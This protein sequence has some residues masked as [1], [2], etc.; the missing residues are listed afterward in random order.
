VI[1]SAGGDSSG[2]HAAVIA[3][4]QTGEFTEA[5]G[6]DSAVIASTGS[7]AS[8]SVQS[9]VMAAYESEASGDRSACVAAYSS[10]ASGAV[11]ACFASDA[12]EAAG[13][14]S[15]TLAT[16]ACFETGNRSVIIGGLNA[17]LHDDESIGGGYSGTAITKSNAN[18]NIKWKINSRYGRAH[19]AG[20]VKVGGNPDDGSGSKV[21][22]IASTG[23]I[24]ADGK[25][26]ATSGVEVEFED[27]GAGNPDPI[28]INKV[29]GR[30]SE[31]WVS[32]TW[33]SGAIRTKSVNCDKV[34]ADSIVLPSVRIS[35]AKA[36][37]CGIKEKSTG[38]FTIWAK[39]EDAD[40]DPQSVT[41]EFI[42]FNPV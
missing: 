42:V 36:I 2:S 20:D 26:T 28:T 31:I 33:T 25:V 35:P 10:K 7:K 4:S 9:A 6:T 23:A 34:G 30:F 17:E 22:I 29:S 18:Q 41:W 24:R 38:Q 8:G 39:N 5:S 3:C 1:A 15:A 21:E 40:V 37:S 12:S 14:R 16:L 27:K 11:S 32:G 13:H 19:F